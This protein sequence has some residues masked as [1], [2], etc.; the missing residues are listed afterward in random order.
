[1][2]AFTM[3]C[4]VRTVV[5]EQKQHTKATN[6]STPPVVC[7]ESLSTRVSGG[8]VLR[9]ETRGLQYPP[10]SEVI[11]STPHPHANSQLAPLTLLTRFRVF[12]RSSFV[13]VANLVYLNTR[14][15]TL[16]APCRPCFFCSPV[17]SFAFFF[18]LV[19]FARRIVYRVFGL[20]RM[21]IYVPARGQSHH[22]LQRRVRRLHGLLQGGGGGKKVRGT[23]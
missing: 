13:A 5:V 8:R 6:P 14:V 22:F 9:Q 11:P 17:L 3:V 10:P 7:R 4:G 1:M 23:G 2:F 15:Y 12:S 16:H 21:D 20:G 19:F 18:C